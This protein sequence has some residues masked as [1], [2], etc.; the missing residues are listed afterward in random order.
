MIEAFLIVTCIAGTGV[1]SWAF[2]ALSVAAIDWLVGSEMLLNGR[3][4]RAE[5]RLE[6][7]RDRSRK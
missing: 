7:L 4:S 1:L 2:L 3:I 6:K 5:A